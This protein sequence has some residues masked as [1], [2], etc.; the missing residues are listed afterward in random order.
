MSESVLFILEP[1]R[2]YSPQ[3][4]PNSTTPHSTTLLDYGNIFSRSVPSFFIP[5]RPLS[6]SWPC[7]VYT[8]IAR[9]GSTPLERHRLSPSSLFT[10]LDTSNDF[11]FR[12]NLVG[13]S[14]SLHW[15]GAVHQV[16]PYRSSESTSSLVARVATCADERFSDRYHKYSSCSLFAVDIS[17]GAAF[18]IVGTALARTLSCQSFFPFFDFRSQTYISFCSLN[19]RSRTTLCISP[20]SFRRPLFASASFDRSDRFSSTEFERDAG[21]F[22]SSRFSRPVRRTS[23][24]NSGSHQLNPFEVQTTVIPP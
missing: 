12:I 17:T 1:V 2:L 14:T 21:R 19:N 9:I 23:M 6:D 7:S 24:P 5:R 15:I 13:W 20:R 3:A 18:C 8:T 16:S 10:T 22:N 11:E 4:T